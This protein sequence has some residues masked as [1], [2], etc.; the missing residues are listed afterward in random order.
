MQSWNHSNQYWNRPVKAN[1]A[2]PSLKSPTLAWLKPLG[3]MYLILFTCYGFV[4]VVNF[5]SVFIKYDI[6]YNWE[7][8]DSVK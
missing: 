5:T 7:E 6:F 3:T 8:K 2:W 1:A 4:G